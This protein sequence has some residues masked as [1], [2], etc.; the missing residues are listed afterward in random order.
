MNSLTARSTVC[1]RFFVSTDFE[2]Q[3]SG[4]STL[5]ATERTLCCV[6]ENYQT[7][8]GVKIPECL[9]PYMHGVTFIPFRKA[10]DK[11]GQ[12]VDRAAYLAKEAAEEAKKAAKQA[13]KMNLDA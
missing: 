2:L 5:T 4:D 10:L 6:L 3:Y 8:D 11:K 13:A 12:L 7:P 1:E 9:Q